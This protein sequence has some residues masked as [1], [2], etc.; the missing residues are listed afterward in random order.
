[1]NVR[2]KTVFEAR[3]LSAT[4]RNE[5]ESWLGCNNAWHYE[6]N[7]DNEMYVLIDGMGCPVFEGNW[8]LREGDDVRH[9]L[10]DT[11]FLRGFETKV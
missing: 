10:S 2:S 11:E 1:M 4:N 6:S 7:S 3:Q 9:L 8:I 5:L